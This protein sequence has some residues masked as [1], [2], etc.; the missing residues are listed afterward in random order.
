VTTDLLI[1]ELSA[2]VRPVRRIDHPVVGLLR[3]AALSAVCVAGGFIV[4]GVRPDLG[5]AVQNPTFLLRAALAILLGGAST[6]SALLASVPGMDRP[7]CRAIP[8]L[9]AALSAAVFI[10]VL[11][12]GNAGVAGLGVTCVERILAF[13]LVPSALVFRAVRRGAPLAAGWVGTLAAV[14]ALAPGAFAIQFICRHDDPLH[15][16]IWHYIPVAIAAS[17][18][19]VLGR[20]RL[21][22]WDER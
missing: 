15:I 10:T 3:W 18:G 6:L 8:A 4:F 7:W 21:T 22:S 2:R 20:R 17:V 11:L 19:A 14:S 5:S 13:S 1:H 12:S 9:M 16:L